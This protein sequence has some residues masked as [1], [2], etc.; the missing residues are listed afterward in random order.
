[1]T[2]LNRFLF[3]CAL[4]SL[5]AIGS[6]SL[7][8]AA[9]KGTGDRGLDAPAPV[10]EPA[11]FQKGDRVVLVGDTFAE[12][13]GL[14]GYVETLLQARHPEHG[15][16]F[17]NLGFSANTPE[18]QMRMPDFGQILN[19][20]N[21]T[22]F[23]TEQKA[24]VIMI[25]FGMAA[26]F[27]GQEGLAKFEKDLATLIESYQRQKFN[28][29]FPPRMVLISCIAHEKL[30]GDLPDPTKH[31]NDLKSY[32]ETMRRVAAA[33]RL[34]FVDLFTP[35]L[36]LMSEPAGDKLTFNGIHLTQYG[37]WAVAQLLGAQLDAGWA[38]WEFE[39]SYR[40]DG[41]TDLSPLGKLLSRRLICPPPPG[42][43]VHPSLLQRHPRIK[44]E[45]AGIK[46][47]ETRTLV[48]DGMPTAAGTVA[49]WK[50]GLIPWGSPAHR[51]TERLR[52]AIV[53]RN[54]QFF[55]RWRAVNGEYIYGRRKAPFGIVNF[56]GEMKQLD[57]IIAAG[58]A[59]VL[60]LNRPPSVKSV[61]LTTD[62]VKPSPS[63]DKPQK[64]ESVFERYQQKL[65]QVGG[66]NIPTAGDPEEARKHFKLPPGYEI[67][68][69][70]SEKDFPIHNPVCMKWDARGRLWVGTN[71][72][73]PQYI[74]GQAPDDQI[75][76]LEDTNNDGKADRSTIFAD[77]LY[78]PIG[79]EL[80]DGGAYVSA[81]PNLLFLKDLNGDDVADVREV[82]LHGFGT[83][84]SHHSI[85]AFQWGPD[86]AFYMMEG[87]F[88]RSMIETPHG[89]LRLYDSGVFR[90][91][92]RTHR[93]EAFVSYG[94]A[95]PWGHVFD[96]WG[97]N[98]IADASGGAN[99]FGLPMTG[100]VDHPRQHPGMKTFT[101]S[102][103]PT[104]GCEIIASRHFP[105]SVQG[106]FIINNCIGF[107]GVKQHRIIE[108]ASG[109]TSLE[110]EPLLQST[111]PNFRPVDI[112]FG[113]DGALYLVDWY[114]P[115][116]G[117][118]QFSIRDP[119]RD[120][121]HGRV[122]RITHKD[123]P[124]VAKPKIAGQPI[125]A[126]LNLLKEYEDRTRYWAR[127]ELRGRDR[128]Q[129]LGELRK[130]L[131][132]LDPTDPDHEHHLLEGLWTYQHLNV[133]ELELLKKLLRAKDY[134]ARAAATRAL[135]YWRER[136]PDALALFQ[137]QVLDE[138]P[139]VRLE[140]VVALSHF[141]IPEAAE[142][143]LLALKS[144]MDYYLD[145][146][147]KETMITLEP[148]WKPAIAS[149]KPFAV[150]NPAG[151][152]YV[153]GK[154][155]TTDLIKMARS[156]PV[157]VALLSRDGVLPEHRK[158]ALEGLARLNRTTTLKELLGA[159]ERL[160]E[161]HDAHGG[162]VL[163]DLAQLLLARPGKELEGV[164]DELES[165][166][167]CGMQPI[168]RQIALVTLVSM[169]GSL[170]RM[171]KSASVN[172][173]SLRDIVEA[174]PLIPN[175][176]V[177][178]SAFDRVYPLLTQLPEALAEQGK[179]KGVEGR[180]VRI[181]LPGGGKTLT[182]AE[183]QVLSDG[184]N[185]AMRGKAT[186]SSMS[187][188][189]KPE[190][191]IDGN[192]SG[193]YGD[194]TATHSREQDLSPWWEVDLGRE[195]PIDAVVVWN[196]TD[197]DLG[198]R[199]DG[200]TLK[201]LD[202]HRQLAFQ[203]AGNPAPSTST[204][205][206][207]ESNPARGLREAAMQAAAVLEGHEEEV[208][209][210]L[211]GF[212]AKGDERDAAI[213]ALR[214]IPKTR[215]PIRQV[216]PLI[217]MLVDYVRSMPP[218][219]RSEPAAL[220]ALQLGNDLA[221]L[222][223]QKEGKELRAKLG[224]LGVN[225]ILVRTVPHKMAFDR[226]K[227]YVEAGK[228]VVVVLENTD[229]APHNL[230]IGTP[231]SLAEI[232]MAAERM[233]TEPDALARGF[234]PRTPKVLH[235]TK[236][237][238][239]KEV[240]RLQF[241]APTSPGEYPYVC[242]FPGHWRLMF[243]TM[244]VVPRLADI[245]IEEQQAVS[246]TIVE[247]RPFVKKW[248]YEDLAPVMVKLDRGGRSYERG[249]AL[250]TAASCVQCHKMGNEG[251]EIGPNLAEVPKKLADRR[252]TRLDLL[253][254]LLEPS[255]V[256]DDKYRTYLFETA[257]G[258]LLTGVILSEDPKTVRIATNPKEKPRE[259]KVDEILERQPSKISLMPE[260]LLVTLNEEEILDLLAYLIA[261]GDS[262]GTIY[263]KR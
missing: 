245:P 88:H 10:T 64:T 234:V 107:Q 209:T 173:R 146:G 181:E 111:D 231:G 168:T 162:H 195:L 166:A 108:E 262:K 260:N 19:F 80:G 164:K 190:R 212:V 121:V 46:A 14:F 56:P 125:P 244:H 163:H 226:A 92:P 28:G 210:T 182:L 129:V 75:I 90:F 186:Q 3:L 118:M 124:L 158:E 84:D 73:Y 55:Y 207:M 2:Q 12:R 258:E 106:N 253:R 141:R 155:S 60:E 89:V 33:K 115:L 214:R 188:G 147:L 174:V 193:A 201:V 175:P 110:I 172:I 66:K 161:S 102:V 248:T 37:Y 176:K 20:G 103:R 120:H 150:D 216:R 157:F 97:Q 184:A 58:D 224:E 59:R 87:T 36:A 138:H 113:P 202:A 218:T 178:A 261:G 123:R 221:A 204:R 65:G 189:G 50:A 171:W 82:I 35:T 48:V 27:A 105:E 235:A 13:E 152:N 1:M 199:L 117:H 194:G 32:T 62:A 233:A 137:T 39:K 78:L 112:T 114:N 81:Q 169:D 159:I 179:K 86:G 238:D 51:A 5:V 8:S 192:T 119:G 18:E 94:F 140:A 131:A 42:A 52:Q 74:P 126:L 198:R 183:V 11:L 38:T 228:P 160:D 142:I 144:P 139:R 49:E 217:G 122:W 85:S 22:Q 43:K 30:P 223:P 91:E 127:L 25:G 229:L 257:K 167:S 69:F 93:I 241:L 40:Q 206:A 149:G 197:G 185:V 47:S 57:E 247:A 132:A 255:K 243:G 236:M 15:L 67:N 145:Y 205:F 148:Y 16:T 170:E 116:I 256:M 177:R 29:K 72:S 230:I 165:L 98:F 23:L 203:K 252:L 134:H 151:A 130:W 227:F 63:E 251:V 77:K 136:V 21:M 254:E 239:P 153:L 237:L 220:D 250:F 222:L 71:P 219:E 208:F 104:C 96:R 156:A 17:R 53:D 143:A 232:G 180:F 154:V 249:K 41:T 68:L 24:D 99:Y 7:P 9:Q 215:A 242:T 135:R 76:I 225:V 211:A 187:H 128:E 4:L 200:F 246:E 26:S 101:T 61:N 45:I 54:Q 240:A 34:P 191:A 70:A 79:F 95:N 213:R 100:H 109:F 44:L 6:A 83:G 263:D 259:L 31:N 133:V 196:R